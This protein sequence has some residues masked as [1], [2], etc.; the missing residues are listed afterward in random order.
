MRRGRLIRRELRKLIVAW[1]EFIADEAYQIMKRRVKHMS[2]MFFAVTLLLGGIILFR[3]AFCSECRG[4]GENNLFVFKVEQIFSWL[5]GG[6]VVGFIIRIARRRYEI[7]KRGI[8]LVVS[9]VGLILLSPLFLII[10]ILIKI[11]SPGP[12]FFR[13]E[14]VGKEGKIFKIWK[15]RTMRENAELETGPVWAED[16]DPRITRIGRFLR[17]SHLDEIPQLI[18][19]FL[20]HMSLIGPRPERPEMMAMIAEHIPDFDKRLLIKPGITGLAQA[21]YS[22]GASIKDAARKLKYDLIYIHRMC[23]MLDLQIILWTVRKVLT[24][25]GAR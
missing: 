11:D 6:S 8:D 19:V 25:E 2:V 9:F 12:V 20:G 16:D 21:R 10:G 5:L 3:S 18:N 13:Q 23:V 24:G 1:R 17:Y 7:I 4:I 14:R 22:Y 15:F